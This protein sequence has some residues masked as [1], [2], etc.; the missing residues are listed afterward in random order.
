MEMESSSLRLP[1]LLL[2]STIN[3]FSSS[4]NCFMFSWISMGVFLRFQSCVQISA[5]NMN[6]VSEVLKSSSIQ[7]LVLN[8]DF[9]ATVDMGTAST[10]RAKRLDELPSTMLECQFWFLGLQYL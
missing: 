9:E 8:S 2:Y 6:G 1:F 5:C 4:A 10:S 7:P 3:Y